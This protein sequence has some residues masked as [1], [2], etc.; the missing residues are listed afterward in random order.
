MKMYRLSQERLIKA[1][2]VLSGSLYTSTSRLAPMPKVW[3]FHPGSC[4]RLVVQAGKKVF[5]I[6]QAPPKEQL[7]PGRGA[8]H[9]F[10]GF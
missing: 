7:N 4:A 10:P 8:V 5:V 1:E 9:P 2:K 6:A 3:R